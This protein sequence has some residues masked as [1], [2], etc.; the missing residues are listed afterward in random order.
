MQ[1][2]QVHIQ[3]YRA[4]KD[5][6]FSIS[7]FNCIIGENNT[8]K[9]SLMNAIHS[10]LDGKK[11]KDSDYYNKDNPVIISADFIIGSSDLILITDEE[12]RRRIST[13][14]KNKSLRLTRKFPLNDNT[15]LTCTKLIPKN[16]KWRDNKITEIL[17]GKRGAELKQV[18]I[19]NYTEIQNDINNINGQITQSKIKEIIDQFI[20]TFPD[21]DMINDDFCDLPTG[22]DASIKSLLP[23]PIFIPAVKDISEDLKT[24]D[25][26]AFG[27]LLGIVLIGIKNEKEMQS[28]KEALDELNQK[29][30]IIEGR[31]KRFPQIINLEKTIEKNIKENFKNIKVNIEIPP[32]DLKTVLQSAEI[33]VTDRGVKGGVET[34]GDGLKRAVLFAL[35]KSLAQLSK[36]GN[37]S[38]D[39]INNYIILF[40]E[41]ELYL[42]PNAQQLIF[43]SLFEISKSIQV[44]VTTH[45]PLFFSARKTKGF[46]KLIKYDS[47]TETPYS[48]LISVDLEKDLDIKDEFQIL[49]FENNNVAFFADKVVLVEGDSDLL[50]LK[51][52]AH[53]INSDWDF[54]RGKIRMVKVCGKGSFFR[55]RKFF[56]KFEIKPFIIS[57][58][59]V[60]VSDFDKLGIDRDSS[61]YADRSSLIE[62]IDKKTDDLSPACDSDDVKSTWAERGNQWMVIISNIIK[63]NKPSKEDFD[64]FQSIKEK[65]SINKVRVNFLKNCD[66]IKLQKQ[67]LIKRLRNEGIFIL[68]RG[69]IEDYYPETI[70]GKDKPL[71]AESF[72]K[73]I[74]DRKKIL[75]LASDIIYDNGEKKNEFEVI[76]STI[77]N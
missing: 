1:I 42:H 64:Y 43:D 76:F 35:L 30:N 26:A 9:S 15:K 12:H 51:H 13:L 22:I 19:D 14:I 47:Q 16:E 65:I 53:T 21:N 25:K 8:G 39:G 11:L 49:C 52:I 62:E 58:L 46:A 38:E 31:D 36:P 7:P 75:S 45:S 17:H 20:S 2:T 74:T 61:I 28:F 6:T 69:C 56:E 5:I 29:L 41:P 34:K 73:T 66:A 37:L 4:L 68:E 24:T 32:P 55:F 70:T 27:S 60:I 44:I 10:F 63:G 50:V 18:A 77:F 67:A 71:K 33:H 57:D 48:D 59:D 54:E 40:E 72:R 3:N 23:N